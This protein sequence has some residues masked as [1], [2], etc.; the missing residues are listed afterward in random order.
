MR[1][2]V[3]SFAEAVKMLMA[4]RGQPQGRAETRIALDRPLKKSER[5]MDAFSIP[6]KTV[7]QSLQTQVVS[8]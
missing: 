8:V 4:D 1:L 2:R 6:G 5:R 7:G 3:F